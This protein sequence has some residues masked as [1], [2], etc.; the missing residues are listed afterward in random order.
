MHEVGMADAARRS[1]HGEKRRLY[2]DFA[3][4]RVLYLGELDQPRAGVRPAHAR[5]HE[6][7]EA[8][9]VQIEKNLVAPDPRQQ[10]CRLADHRARH[11]LAKIVARKEFDPPNY[12]L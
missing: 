11:E 8:L 5:R 12:E 4:E 2:L 9:V 6:R 7:N 3:G 1:R 10:A